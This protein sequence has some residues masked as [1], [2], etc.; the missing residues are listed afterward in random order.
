MC[1]RN[2][3]KCIMCLILEARASLEARMSTHK[4][5]SL[6]EMTEKPVYILK[7]KTCPSILYSW[8][9]KFL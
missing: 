2:I 7:T 6:K 9:V 4:S 1:L 5:T 8:T 3:F